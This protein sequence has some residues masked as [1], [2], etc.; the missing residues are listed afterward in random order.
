MV[1]FGTK[2]GQLAL[3]LPQSLLG[4]PNKICILFTLWAGVAQVGRQRRQRDPQLTVLAPT[5]EAG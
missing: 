4:S 3:A 5:R 2:T 1:E